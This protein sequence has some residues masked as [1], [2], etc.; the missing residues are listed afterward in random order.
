M[1]IKKISTLL[2]WI[3]GL[4][5]IW[6]FAYP[7]FY[8][9]SVF[10]NILIPIIGILFAFK[11][12]GK[13]GIDYR[14]WKNTPI[15][16]ID[17]A[18]LFPSFALILRALMD[19]KI[20]G[21]K[22]IFIYALIISIPL[23]LILFYGTKEYL[24]GKKIFTGF[25]WGI[26]FTFT[27]GYGTAILTNALLDQSEPVFYKAKIINKE[28]ENGKT[29]A[30]RIDFEPWGPITENDLMRVSKTEFE[31]LN[32]NDSIELELRPG[33]LKTRWIRKK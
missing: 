18:I 30:Y 25:F 6:L 26:L 10:I 3:G 20:L 23:I 22:N 5:A 16:K 19:I 24:I 4:S 13:V 15:P 1:T 28:I 11:H 32:V 31:R 27:F 2:N 7:K 21:F 33:F 29:I 14:K 8:G 9:L 17:S 12:Q